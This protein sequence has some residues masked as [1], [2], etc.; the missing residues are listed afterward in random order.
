MIFYSKELSPRG[1]AKRAER[2]LFL[3]SFAYLHYTGWLQLKIS[4]S[5]EKKPVANFML[6]AFPLRF[7]VA[8]MS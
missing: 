6:T 3:D 1:T 5:S 7:H 4:V 2:S 8:L